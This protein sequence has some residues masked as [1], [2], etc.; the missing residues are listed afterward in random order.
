MREL[1]NEIEN[2]EPALEERRVL[3]TAAKVLR[4]NAG[5]INLSLGEVDLMC[6]ILIRAAGTDA[7]P[8]RTESE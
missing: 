4:I 7:V 2:Q 5:V 1:A 6:R 3:A 8:Y